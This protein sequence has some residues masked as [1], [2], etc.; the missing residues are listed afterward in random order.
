MAGINLE[1]IAGH[2][3]DATSF[4]LPAV[5]GGSTEDLP[6]ICG[7]QI[8]KYMVLEVAVA[9]LMVAIFVPLAIR[10]KS[11]K[12][13]KGRFW[14]LIEVFLLYL[15]DQVIRPSI[16]KHDADRF[17]PFL[18]TLF[19][20][21]LFCNLFGMLP[22][23]GSPTGS[24]AVTTVM[25]LSTFGVVTISGM[26]RYGLVGFW[27]GLVPHMD[28]PPALSIILKPMLFVIELA[29]L[30]I[31]HVVLAIRLVANMFAGHMVL[32]VFLSFIPMTAG[33]VW[34][35][36]VTLGSIGMSVC[37]SM[38]ELFVA[39]LQA[40]IFMFLSALF[41]GMAVHQH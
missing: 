21:I 9:I 3:N 26:R 36:P 17:V 1:D 7:F 37:L 13:P 31:K 16:G 15:R 30:L 14:N 4:H 11:G 5:L 41:I 22:W 20:F 25:A 2:V 40:Y 34:W 24:L 33:L 38:L 19:F 23:C 18:W 6:S 12:P 28:L 8:T 32:A 35:Y 29:G 10:L 27:T 39:F